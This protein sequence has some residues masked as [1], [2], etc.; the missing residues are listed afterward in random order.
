MPNITNI[1]PQRVPFIDERTGLISREWYRFLLNLFQI[2][3]SGTSDTSVVDLQ[4]VPQAQ[5]DFGDLN[6][7][8][9]QAALS[10]VPNVGDLN[11]LYDQ[12]QLSYQ[13]AVIGELQSDIDALKVAPEPLEIHPIP[14]GSFFDTTTQTGSTTTPTL[15][16]FDTIDQAK[17]I[18]RG[19]PTS[20]IYVSEA[21]TFNFQFSVQAKTSDANTQDINIWLRVNG[22]DVVGSNGRVSIPAK[23]GAIDGHIIAG[24]N[25]F[26]T[27]AA[28]DYLELVWL[29]TTVTTT[30]AYYA[31]VTGPPAI[32]ATYSV[33]LTAIKVNITTG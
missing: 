13:N 20:R 10:Y 19:T 28:G 7:S 9:S 32:P 8:Y 17:G 23:H 14:Y 18:Y 16:T 11:N 26:L 6:D 30:L 27:M 21:G 3:G 12:A 33:V 1:P 22:V 25:F 15:I 31:A 2:T 29:P 4:L 24:W 5:V